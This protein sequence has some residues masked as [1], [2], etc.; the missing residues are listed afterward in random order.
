MATGF[1]DAAE[2]ALL[3]DASAGLGRTLYL[4]L[5]KWTGS[6]GTGAG[7]TPNDDGTL[8]TNVVE[9]SGGGYARVS[10]ASGDWAAATGTAPASKNLNATKTWTATANYGEVVA[11]G[12]Y[13]ASTSG[14]L[15]CFGPVTNS[16]GTATYVTVNNGDTFGFDASNPIKVQ[17][18]DP[19]D[20]F[21]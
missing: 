21:G 19:T 10:V 6:S 17:L 1:T 16:A 8:P 3:D 4:A 11:W 7:Q 20:T 2:K 12:L 14:N 15:V 18:G 13:D 9:V 5:F